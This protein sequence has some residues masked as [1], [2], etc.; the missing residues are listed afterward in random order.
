MTHLKELSARQDL[1]VY[2]YNNMLPELVWHYGTSIPKLLENDSGPAQ[3][4]IYTT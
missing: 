2:D 3:E 4:R 1:Q